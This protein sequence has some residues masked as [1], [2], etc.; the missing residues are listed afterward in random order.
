MIKSDIWI[1]RMCTEFDSGPGARWEP[2]P[3]VTNGGA[4][5]LANCKIQSGSVYLAVPNRS[6]KK[7]D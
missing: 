5:C 6:T 4:W 1:E 3:G 2:A 7:Q